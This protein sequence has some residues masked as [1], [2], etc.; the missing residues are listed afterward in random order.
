MDQHSVASSAKD[1]ASVHTATGVGVLN[2]RSLD[3]VS[4]LQSA[5]AEFG[6]DE[7]SVHLSDILS[8]TASRKTAATTFYEL[9]VLGTAGRLSFEQP[10]PYGEIL[11]QP[12][13]FTLTLFLSITESNSV[14]RLPSSNKLQQ[15]EHSIPYFHSV[16]LIFTMYQR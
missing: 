14:R 16:L 1:S 10:R 7:E 15:L 9:L 8:A 13:V 6:Q 5:F 11:I 2:Q 3:V 12:T 4:T